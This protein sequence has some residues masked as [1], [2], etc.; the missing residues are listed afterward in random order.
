MPVRSYTNIKMFGQC[1]AKYQA[2]TVDK[3]V[4]FTTTQQQQD[5]IDAHAALEAYITTR[6]PLP[7][8][9][10]S[11]QDV[12]EAIVRFKGEKLCEKKLAIDT[13][14]NPVD[15]WDKS[16]WYRGIIDVLVINGDKARILDYKRGNKAHQD[17]DQLLENAIL[18]FSNYPEVDTITASFIYL[19][20]GDVTKLVVRR[21]DLHTLVVR[22]SKKEVPIIRAE[23]LN[24]FPTQKSHL[25]NYC[26]VTT[27]RYHNRG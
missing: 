16:V 21:E 5:G 13:D 25:C 12:V 8:R 4:P 26:Q 7:A 2:M 14:V 10:S 24:S 1:P 27:C 3:S 6:T 20:A 23:K 18:V 19:E 11:Y 22:L 9:F 17:D 15:Y